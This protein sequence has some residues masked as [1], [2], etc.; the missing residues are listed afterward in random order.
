MCRP[1][2]AMELQQRRLWRDG[3]R[4]WMGAAI[5]TFSSVAITLVKA[6]NL[7]LAEKDNMLLEKFVPVASN[8]VARTD[9][10]VL[11]IDII[12][13][14]GARVRSVVSNCK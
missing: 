4:H 2:D 3:A 5:L 1:L 10:Y 7:N 6:N 13:V 8:L 12:C 9:I 14:V 11:Y